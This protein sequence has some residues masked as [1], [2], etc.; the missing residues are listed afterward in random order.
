MIKMKKRG[1]TK[2]YLLYY[3]FRRLENFI[4]VFLTENNERA[5]YCPPL[6]FDEKWPKGMGAIVSDTY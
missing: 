5:N 1:L 4:T 2:D 6:R 3:Y